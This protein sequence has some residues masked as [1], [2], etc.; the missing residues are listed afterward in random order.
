[1]TRVCQR[2]PQAAP[3]TPISNPRRATPSSEQREDSG[4]AP[5]TQRADPHQAKKPTPSSIFTNVDELH[6]E[7][8][9]RGALIQ[10][11][12]TN[13]S[14]GTRELAIRD[15]DVN[16]LVFATHPPR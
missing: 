3:A 10:L 5:E 13:Q 1:L 7:L 4:S 12:P 9:S 11:P 2:Q 16:V 6:A 14:W 15:P 8:A